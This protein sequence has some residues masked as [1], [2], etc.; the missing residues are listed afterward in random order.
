[1]KSFCISLCLVWCGV[2]NAA[3]I[4]TD[5]SLADAQ[6]KYNGASSGDTILWPLNGGPFGWNNALS[7]NN[8]KSITLNANKSS[9]IHSGGYTGTLISQSGAGSC[10]SPQI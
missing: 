3:V 8:S 2:V 6:A 4:N 9:V 10:G 7:I 1:M 5:G